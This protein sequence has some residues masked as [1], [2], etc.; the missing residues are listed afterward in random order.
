MQDA[1]RAEQNAETNQGYKPDTVLG[2]CEAVGN[3]LGFNSTLLRIAFLPLLFFAPLV[4][5]GAYLGLGLVVVASR[6]IFPKP[7]QPK[8]EAQIIRDSVQHEREP[9]LVAA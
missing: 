7:R 3:E 2:L 4:M 1:I 6:L 8:V 9:E 5:I